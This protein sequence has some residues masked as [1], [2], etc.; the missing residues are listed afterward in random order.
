MD[1]PE[2]SPLRK[3]IETIQE[4]GMRA[5]DV[6]ADLL[7]IARGVATGKEALNL[8]TVVE[9]YLGSAEHLKLKRIHPLSTF[10]AEFDSELLNIAGSASHVKKVL[11]NLVVNA[12]E[13]I[14]STGTVTISSMNHYLDEPLRRCAQG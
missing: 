1:L 6:V 12:S 4:S 5:A 8:N 11:M 3:P 13:A 10:K 14:E 2:D 9:E 7:T